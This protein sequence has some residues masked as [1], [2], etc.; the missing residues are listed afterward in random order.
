MEFPQDENGDVL[1]QMHEAG[2][3]LSVKQDID[4]WHLFDDEDDGAEMV[5]R[6]G[7]MAIQVRMIENRKQSGWDVQCIV[8]MVPTHAAITQMERKLAEIADECGGHP[9]GWGV[10]QP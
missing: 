7:A 9:Q 5:R 4:F 2:F 8:S 3:D 1:R 10:L 6:V